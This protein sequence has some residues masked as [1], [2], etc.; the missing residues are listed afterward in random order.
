MVNFWRNKVSRTT[1]LILW[2][3]EKKTRKLVQK[4]GPVYINTTQI[5]LDRL[6]QTN[7][8]IKLD[9]CQILLFHA[10]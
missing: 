8:I 10:R 7:G 2:T 6:P 4:H 5:V 9:I 3:I 1:L